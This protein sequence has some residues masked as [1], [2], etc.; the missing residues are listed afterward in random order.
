MAGESDW[1]AALPPVIGARFKGLNKY[2]LAVLEE[3]HRRKKLTHDDV[4]RIQIE[5]AIRVMLEF[6]MDGANAAEQAVDALEAVGIPGFA[7]GKEIFTGRNASVSRGRILAEHLAQA[8][9]IPTAAIPRLER[10]LRVQILER[11]DELAN[12]RS[13]G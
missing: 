10:P 7:V 5:I 8:V 1:L 11:A 13:L 4:R 2:V 12:A 6:F 9:G 3:E